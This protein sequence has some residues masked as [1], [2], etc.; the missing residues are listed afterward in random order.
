MTGLI[1]VTD[2]A[3]LFRVTEKT[4][5]TWI[6]AGMPVEQ[7]GSQGGAAGS[8]KHWLDLEKCVEWYFADNYE[9]LELDRARSRLATVQ[10]DKTELENELRRSDVAEISVIGAVID[11]LVSNAKMNLLAL[12]RKIASELEGMNV[13]QREETIER[14]IKQSLEQLSAYRPHRGVAKNRRADNARPTEAAAVADGKPVGRR[15]PRAK[16]GRKRG[17]GKVANSAG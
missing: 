10:A 13:R 4:I 5:L 9:R 1:T 11:D 6:K 8:G 17:A 12:P 2:S 7:R 14:Q 16:P 3:R 15:K